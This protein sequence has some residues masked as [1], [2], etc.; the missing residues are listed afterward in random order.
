[1]WLIITDYDV[2]ISG[3]DIDSKTKEMISKYFVG[4]NNYNR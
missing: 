1:M 3:G 4:R 2:V